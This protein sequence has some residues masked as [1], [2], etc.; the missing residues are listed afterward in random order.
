MKVYILHITTFLLLFAACNNETKQQEASSDISSETNHN[1]S[2]V[3]SDN[4]LFFLVGTYTREE[5]HVNGKAEGIHLV[6]LN[7]ESGEMMLKETYDAG[8]NPSY[9]IIHP[10]NK[11][12]YAVNETGGKPDEFYGNVTALQVDDQK[13]LSIINTQSSEGKAPCHL[14]FSN[15]KT[16]VFLANYGTGSV[17]S[18]NLSMEG[19]M[20]RQQT[21]VRFRDRGPHERQEAPHAHY[22]QQLRNGDVIA[23]DL[24]TDTLHVL[25]FNGGQLAKTDQHVT[26]PA[27]S[28]PRHIAEHP[29]LPMF[30]V[31]NELNGTISSV[32]RNEDNSYQLYQN[33]RTTQ[34]QN[35]GTAS[36]A[37]IK[38]TP[39]GRFLY[40]SNRG[41]FNNIAIYEISERGELNLI[42]HQSSLGNVPR[43]F[44]ISPNGKYLVVA[45][46]NSDNLVSFKI[47]QKRGFLE[48]PIVL[49]NVATPVSVAFFY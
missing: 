41:D 9:V 48:D 21:V 1:A 45:N 19:K 23:S 46:Q 5:G 11:L 17:T 7:P 49:K 22:I 25:S 47:H 3:D 31:I 42:G 14:S 16:H 44:S 18:Y 43:D 29:N 39:N 8:I 28:G 6:S 10:N 13:S 34:E 37:A 27:G 4:N 24:G 36:C 12:A 40:A 38:I 33:V 26:V 35:E 2:F 15:Q 32:K 20:S 30:F